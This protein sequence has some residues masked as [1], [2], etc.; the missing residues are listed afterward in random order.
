MFRRKVP[1][2]WIVVGDEEIPIAWDSRRLDKLIAKL[3]K[4]I[5]KIECE[6]RKLNKLAK[7]FL[8]VMF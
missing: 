3:I 7:K 8:G 2:M 1:V 4:N 5:E 6:K